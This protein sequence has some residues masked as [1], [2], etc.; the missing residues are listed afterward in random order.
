MV[1]CGRYGDV[2]LRDSLPM[3]YFIDETF[4]SNPLQPIDAAGKQ[5]MKELI[6]K[7]VGDATEGNLLKTLMTC[8]WTE[9]NEVEKRQS[10]NEKILR[11]F[12]ELSKDLKSSGGPYL[13][14]YQFTIADIALIPFIDRSF[15][16]LEHHRGL[17]IPQTEEYAALHAWRKAYSQRPSY[18]VT[19][20]DRL[21]RSMAVQPFGARKRNEYLL[22]ASEGFFFNVLD[23][24]RQQLRHAPPGKST[25]D[26]AS[27]KRE[28]EKKK[29]ANAASSAAAAPSSSSSS[30]PFS[31]RSA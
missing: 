2:E 13:L 11:Q 25:A 6:E 24:V 19:N 22:E 3:I 23:E 16:Y 15:L 8:F 31:M 7:Y 5:R 29:Q 17:K 26:I 14:G 30:V 28:K 9:D 20:A 18:K 12:A 21:D 4:K 10:L 1:P 27:A